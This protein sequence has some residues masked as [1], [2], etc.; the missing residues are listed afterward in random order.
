MN[1]GR[2]PSSPSRTSRLQEKEEMQNLNERLVIYIDT[3]RRLEFE[4][5]R[6][7]QTVQQYSENSVRDVADIK[8][9]YETELEDAKRLIDELA[10][11]KAR[12]E[13]ELNKHKA[14][15]EEALGKLNRRDREFRTLEDKF[16]VVEGEA[17]EYKKR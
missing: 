9:L 8:K 10:K 12:I 4:N 14:D 2:S 15:A 1:G 6:L 5:N 3:V 7:Q 17:L 13:I 16:R 11:E